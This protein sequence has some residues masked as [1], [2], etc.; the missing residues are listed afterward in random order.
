MSIDL[1]DLN[2]FQ[3]FYRMK[4]L[5]T[6]LVA[7]LLIIVPMVVYYSMDKI[8]VLKPSL[9]LSI[10]EARARRFRLII[11]VRSP[12]EREEL[13]F[14]PNSIPVSVDRLSEVPTYNSNKDISILVYSNGDYRAE[15]AADILYSM[16]YHKVRYITKPY[17]ALMPG[18]SI[19]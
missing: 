1:M 15:K 7:L 9:A 10:P 8:N 16:G 5:N 17:L 4:K 14:F 13:G 12:K 2:I 6:L 19:Q 18:S 11:D 3:D